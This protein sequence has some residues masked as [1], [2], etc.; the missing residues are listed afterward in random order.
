MS[1]PFKDIDVFILCGGL[2]KRLRKLNLNAPKPMAKIGGRPF[3]DMIIDYMADFG[4]R[5]FILGL[6]YK[7]EDIKKYYSTKPGQ[8]LKIIFSQEKSP[9]G[10]GGAVK[11][12]KKMIKS[13]HFLV[14]NGDSFY[15]F[16]PLDF[17]SFHKRKKSLVTILLKRL[18]GDAKDYGT[19]KIDKLSN[20]ISFQEKNEKA[21]NGL[22]N[23][24]VYLFNNKVFDLMPRKRSF[25]L[26]HELF[27]E[28]YGRGLFGYV[29]SGYFID[30]GTPERFF[31]ARKHFLK[32]KNL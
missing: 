3:L 5:R 1:N 9:L 14:L 11:K 8:S 20:I 6:G 30:I 12:A 15:Q 19:V 10:T 26:E 2:G 4:F 29:G 17:L 28:L 25:S 23:S 7:G 27:P 16:N 24:G 31:K 32:N 21:K 22:I 13:R 18:C